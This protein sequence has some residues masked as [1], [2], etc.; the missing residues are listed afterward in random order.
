MSEQ[1]ATSSQMTGIM[2]SLQKAAWIS[3]NTSRQMGLLNE[4]VAE[5]DR[6]IEDLKHRMDVREQ[7]EIVN[8]YQRRQ[9]KRAVINRVNYL[10][11]IEF[12]GGHIA[13]HCI[14]DD[15]NYRGG[16]ISRCYTDCKK[17]GLMGDPY[18]ETLAINYDDVI[19]AIQAWVPNVEDG[20]EGYKRYLDIRREEREAKKKSA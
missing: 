19:S 17:K 16:F 11:D 9:I 12:N 10:L 8:T 1:I 15:Q 20:V 7:R 13:E 14:S 2:E 3:E 5:H 4:R 18:S 6:E